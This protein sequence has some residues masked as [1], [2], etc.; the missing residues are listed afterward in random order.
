MKNII[1]IIIII[2]VILKTENVINRFCIRCVRELL[3]DGNI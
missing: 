2:I 3:K 1:I